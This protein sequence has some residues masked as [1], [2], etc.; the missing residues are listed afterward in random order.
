MHSKKKRKIIILAVGLLVIAV[1]LSTFL[2]VNPLKPLTGKTESISV[3]MLPNE[4]ESLI[5]VANNQKYFAANG[6]NV[7]YQAYPSGLA[8]AQALLGGHVNIAMSTEFILTE[9]A[10]ANASLY[11]IGTSCKFL[12]FFLVARTDEGINT[13]SDL[14]DKIIG[15]SRGT[16]AEFYLGQ[17]LEL[18][19][20]DLSNVTLVNVP[21]VQSQNALA[22]GTVNAVL[23]LEPYVNQIE[24]FLGSKVTAWPA[25]ANQFGYNDLLCTM[26][27]AQQNPDIIVRLL[28][29][30]VQ[31]ENFVANHEN[32]AI[33][34]VKLELNYSNTYL[35]SVWP[36]YQF[37]VSLDQSQVLAMQDEARWL[38]SN[39]M[40]NSTALPNFVNYM[41]VNGLESASPGAVDI[42]G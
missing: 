27:W 14:N 24:T 29:S 35:P 22:N 33:N 38:I 8:A 23:T 2:Y 26:A 17:F 42:I 7:T 4:T 36:N 10:L 20:L 9:E 13:I 32:E 31:A 6:L 39:D 15:V 12:S 34:I 30:L 5:Y 3:G 19:R 25:Q 1:L 41:Y 40:I 18:N 16:I 28:K 37:S 21:F 11:A